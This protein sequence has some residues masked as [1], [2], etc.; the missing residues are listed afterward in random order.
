VPVVAR[1]MTRLAVRSSWC[2]RGLRDRVA[3]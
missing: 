1:A 3:V 2:L